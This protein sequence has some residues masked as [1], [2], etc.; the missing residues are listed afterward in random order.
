MKACLSWW[1]VVGCA[2]R[3]WGSADPPAANLSAA[4]AKARTEQKLVLVNFTSLGTNWCSACQ[5]LEVEVSQAPEF[6]AYSSTNFV[7]L[8]IEDQSPQ[9]AAL[10][11]KYDVGSWPTLLV[12]DSKGTILGRVAGYSKG[13]GGTKII[14]ELEK[15][16][17]RR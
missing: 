11:E 9:S 14:T 7:V 12:L 6:L 15:I 3:V 1:V 13:T 4:L 2:F 17:Q 5:S 10:E 8:M 16:R